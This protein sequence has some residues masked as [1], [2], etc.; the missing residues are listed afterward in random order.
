MNQNT[1]D[2]SEEMVSLHRQFVIT[3]QARLQSRYMSAL[4]LKYVASGY[5]QRMKIRFLRSRFG[6]TLERD[7]FK[8]GNDNQIIAIL[9]M[10]SMNEMYIFYAFVYTVLEGCLNAKITSDQ[11]S[12]LISDEQKVNMLKRFRNAVFH[13]QKEMQSEKIFDFIES[14]ETEIWIEHLHLAIEQAFLNHQAMKPFFDYIAT[15]YKQ[16]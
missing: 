10:S 16:R 7:I 3:N 15:K 8:C 4:F 9:F 2:L 1:G 11:I 5:W 14:P 12:N 13:V 6:T